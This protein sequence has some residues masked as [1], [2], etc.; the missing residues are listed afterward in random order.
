MSEASAPE[1]KARRAP[2][3]S[4]VSSQT[5][6]VQKRRL[7]EAELLLEVSRKMSVTDSLDEVLN[8]LLDATTAELNAERGTLFLNDY[9]TNELY[10]RVAQG[11]FRREIRILNTTGVA[12]HV[13]TTGQGA[14]VHD[15]YADPRFNR[16]VD[17][18]TG[19][20]TRNILC[21]PI[22]TAKGLV[23]GVAQLLNKKKGRFMAADLELLTK[24]AAQGA[25]A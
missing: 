21:V 20:V 4:G 23:V 22:K 2:A 5:A 13:F 24:M 19:Y 10:S 8:T 11:S 16:S 9:E 1:S 6:A 15:A 3:P 12:G 17:E 7:R 14:I 18:R 25:V